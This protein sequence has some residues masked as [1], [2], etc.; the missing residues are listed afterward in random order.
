MGSKILESI[1]RKDLFQTQGYIDGPWVD[2]TSG[3]TF[4]VLDPATLDK[5]ASVPEMGSADTLKAIQSARTAF[6]LYKQ[7]TA[8]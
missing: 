5:I 1:A 4:D 2:A 6:K 3:K 8:R 7:M